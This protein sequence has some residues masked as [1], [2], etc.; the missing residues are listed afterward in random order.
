MKNSFL[1]NQTVPLL[2][3]LIPMSHSMHL[4]LTMIHPL[5]HFHIPWA[6]CNVACCHAV[7]CMRSLTG[8]LLTRSGNRR[9]SFNFECLRRQSSQ[10]ELPHQRTALP[11]HLMQHQVTQAH[12]SRALY[13]CLHCFEH[14]DTFW[15]CLNLLTVT[16]LSRRSKTDVSDFPLLI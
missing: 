8:P 10:D 12:V 7:S 16:S 6:L 11:L 3:A 5:T 14:C 1:S 2:N 13:A 4:T 15:T 9:P